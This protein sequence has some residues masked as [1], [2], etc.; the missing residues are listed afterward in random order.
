M[1]GGVLA[2]GVEFKASPIAAGGVG[3]L[4]RPIDH[5]AYASAC[6]RGC[7]F[8]VEN[9][10]F[11]GRVNKHYQAHRLG[12][13]VPEFA[14]THVGVIG[15]ARGAY[16]SLMGR[17]PTRDRSV[18]RYLAGA[19]RLAIGRVKGNYGDADVERAF[20]AI[21]WHIQRYAPRYDWASLLTFGLVQSN[22][23]MICSELVGV[24][25]NELLRLD[26]K[27]RL[28]VPDRLVLPWEWLEF[29]DIEWMG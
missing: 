11:W 18:D 21:T 23:A 25:V 27:W 26:R 13:E 29:V 28:M 2:G 7:L 4:S 20:N 8:F 3:T 6:R 9:S 5:V 12:C 10:G 24:F 15:R 19:R 17:G 14:P 1:S 16:E 22:N